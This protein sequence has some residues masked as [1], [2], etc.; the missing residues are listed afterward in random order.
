MAV[1]NPS[2][3][4][5]SEILSTSRRIAVVGASAKPDRASHAVARYLI[6]RGYEVLPVNPA[7]EEIL[8]QK[9]YESLSEI[10]GQIDI[11]DVFRKSEAT[12]PIID[13]ALKIGAPVIWLQE[14]VINEA[15][16]KRAEAE[17]VTVLQD[18]CIKKELA[19]R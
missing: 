8:G 11:V 6:E 9:C 12:D 19:K 10:E 5:I 14:G 1:T 16:A 17:G 3:E 15:G 2:A 18:I 13:E 4:K 7:E